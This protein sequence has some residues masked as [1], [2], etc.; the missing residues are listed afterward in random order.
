MFGFLKNM[1]FASL[2][3]NYKSK[4]FALVIDCIDI[5][6]RNCNPDPSF[7]IKQLIATRASKNSYNPSQITQLNIMYDSLK[8]F[9][10]NTRYKLA[11][12]NIL[13]IEAKINML[14]FHKEQ[15]FGDLI[16]DFMDDIEPMQQLINHEIPTEIA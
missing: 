1:K 7:I 15:E 6:K 8:D 14:P 11:F 12:A 5:A 16:G 10:T 3:S 9:G 2:T 13:L 4:S